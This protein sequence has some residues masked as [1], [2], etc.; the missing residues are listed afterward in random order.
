MAN[1]PSVFQLVS[2][3]VVFTLQ[4]ETGEEAKEW[5]SSVRHEINRSRNDIMRKSVHICAV[6]F[7]FFLLLFFLLIFYF[8]LFL[9]YFLFLNIYFILFICF[10]KNCIVNFIL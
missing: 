4:A 1:E 9:F 10:I 6:C 3:Q 8:I 2:L 7:F 5:I